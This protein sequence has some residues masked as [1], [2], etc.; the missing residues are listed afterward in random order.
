GLQVLLLGDRRRVCL[1]AAHVADAS[2]HSRAELIEGA[3]RR[4]L[5]LAQASELGAMAD[6][7]GGDVVEVDLDHQLGAQADPLEILAGAPAAGVGRPAL[8]RLIRYE[9]SDE[10]LLLGGAQARAVP[11]DAPLGA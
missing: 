11:D 7:P 1:L 3:L 2:G 5:V 10:P 4:R 6:A 8:A 9:I